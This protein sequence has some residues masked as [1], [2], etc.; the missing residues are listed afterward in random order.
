[1]SLFGVT[2]SS[3]I[4]VQ[5]VPNITYNKLDTSP[6]LEVI[7]TTCQNKSLYAP[8]PKATYPPPPPAR[9]C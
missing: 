2:T 3:R 8:T 7:T 5:I 6:R 4:I 1:M 9:A